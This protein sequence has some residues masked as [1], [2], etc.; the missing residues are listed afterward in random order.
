METQVR[1]PSHVCPQCGEWWVVAPLQQDMWLII[2]Y[3]DH[4]HTWGELAVRPVCP[5]C[6]FITLEEWLI[7]DE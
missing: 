2:R 6:H 3:A 4:T 7:D 1:T 5:D